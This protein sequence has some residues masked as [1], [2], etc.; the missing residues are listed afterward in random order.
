MTS[1]IVRMFY[2]H[3]P[4]AREYVKQLDVIHSDKCT[5]VYFLLAVYYHYVCQ[6]PHHPLFDNMQK[7]RGRP[8]QTDD[9]NVYFGGQKEGDHSDSFPSL[10]T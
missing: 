4:S 6:L 10:S 5:K 9:V 8:H 3:S 1:H 2:F 7:Q